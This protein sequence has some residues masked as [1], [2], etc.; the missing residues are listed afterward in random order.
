[1]LVKTQTPIEWRVISEVK[2]LPGPINWL[3]VSEIFGRQSKVA[4]LQSTSQQLNLLN[5]HMTNFLVQSRTL[6]KD[7]WTQT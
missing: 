2:K 7:G 4:T 6:L 5:Q 1:M 3:M